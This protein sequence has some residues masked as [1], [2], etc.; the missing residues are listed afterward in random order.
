MRLLCLGRFFSPTSPETR[1][2]PFT[3]VGGSRPQELSVWLQV[4]GLWLRFSAAPGGKASGRLMRIWAE[5]PG[6]PQPAKPTAVQ[7]PAG[8]QGCVLSPLA[9]PARRSGLAHGHLLGREPGRL[10]GL[11]WRLRLRQDLCLVRQTSLSDSQPGSSGQRQ[12]ALRR[13]LAHS[14]VLFQGSGVWNPTSE[15]ILSPL[16]HPQVGGFLSLGIF[17]LLPGCVCVCVCKRAL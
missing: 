3:G 6:H 2:E 4:Q 11:I 5:R 12:G 16:T 13:V 15:M 8:F 14:R 7:R 10:Q 1:R 9:G 17:V